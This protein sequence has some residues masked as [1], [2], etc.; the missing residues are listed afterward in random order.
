MKTNYKSYLI[1]V[2]EHKRNVFKVCWNKGLYL[3]AFTHD[4][5]KFLPSEFMIYAKNFYGEKDCKYCNKYLECDYNQIGLGSG[6]WAKE[7]KDYKYKGFDKAWNEHYK[8]N[9]HHWQYWEN[10]KIPIKY[11]KQMICDWEAMSLKFGGS[12][13]EY[14]MKNYDKIKINLESRC[15]L[16]FE[17]GLIDCTCMISNVTWKNYCDNLNISMEED[18]KSIRR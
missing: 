4:L 15:L 8:K 10:K 13:Q 3:H 7:C 18:L 17:L 16:E 1:Y 14:Y 5:S 9:K 11:I 6:N 2:L 12:C